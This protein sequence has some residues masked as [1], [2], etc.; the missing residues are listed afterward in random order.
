[1][2][3][4]DIDDEAVGRAL[5]IAQLESFV[6]G[7]PDGW[8][9]PVGEAGVRLSGGQ[10]QRIAI[11]RAIYRNA[12]LLVLD[13]GT[14][15]LDDSTEDRFVSALESARG[16]LALV[17]IA[18]RTSTLRV[19]DA[20]YLVEDGRVSPLGSYEDFLARAPSVGLDDPA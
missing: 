18:H 14:S 19:C 8:D 4:D 7:L 20:I 11:A 9:T 10:R 13:E 1:M 3:E 2:E 16:H 5:R 17:M 12:R 15:A 6:A